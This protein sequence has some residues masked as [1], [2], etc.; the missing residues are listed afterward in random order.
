MVKVKERGRT[1]APETSNLAS[2]TSTNLARSLREV[3]LS[4]ELVLTTTPTAKDRA[5]AYALPNTFTTP[6]KDKT[7]LRAELAV[8]RTSYNEFLDVRAAATLAASVSDLPE[9]EAVLRNALAVARSISDEFFRAQALAAVAPEL[10]DAEWEA[11]LREAVTAVKSISDGKS[12]T[13]ALIA[14]SDCYLPE[15]LHGDALAAARTI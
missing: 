1:K 10:P 13:A 6:T 9:T 14:L 15:T 7:A 12:R 3:V 4:D 11:A 5:P 2:G 8:E